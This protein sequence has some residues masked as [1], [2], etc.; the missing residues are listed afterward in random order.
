MSGKSNVVSLK[1]MQPGGTEPGAAVPTDRRASRR[2]ATQVE[3]VSAAWDLVRTQG[4]AGLSMRDLGDRVGMRAQSVYGYF[5]SKD[6]IYDAMFRQGYEQYLAW[7]GSAGD[8]R[9]ADPVDDLRA[10]AHRFFAFC[11]SDPV[12]YQLM[13]QRTIPGFEPSPTSYALAV[14]ALANMQADL[15]R[16]GISDPEASDLATAVFAGLVSQQLAN[17]PGG[18]RWLGLVDRAVVMVVREIAPHLLDVHSPT[19]KPRSPR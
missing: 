3:I 18:E 12:R 7:M 5:A 13:F 4:L 11:T 19:T 15:A 8:S 17:D 1:P 14:D 9:A 10:L 16:T 2:A 6:A